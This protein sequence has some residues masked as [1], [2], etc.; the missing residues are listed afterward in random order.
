[1][2]RF[3]AGKAVFRLVC[4]LRFTGFSAANTE[5]Q[6]VNHSAKLLAQHRFI[7]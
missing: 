1:M 3:F 5:K 2:I 7:S 4:E 6:T